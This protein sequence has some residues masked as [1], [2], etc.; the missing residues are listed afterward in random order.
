MLRYF[1]TRDMNRIDSITTATIVGAIALGAYWWAL[2]YF[3]GGILLSVIA[4]AVLA[5]RTAKCAA[6]TPDHTPG[7]NHSN[8]PDLAAPS[9]PAKLENA[10]NCS[11]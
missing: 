9:L 8:V 10:G 7:T 1:A 4:E 2:G 5:A 3:V 6:Q 11:T